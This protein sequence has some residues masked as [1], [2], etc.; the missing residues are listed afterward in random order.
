MRSSMPGPL[1]R[2]ATGIDRSLGLVLLASLAGLVAGLLL[3]A[4]TVRSMFIGRDF[5]LL[6]SVFSFLQSGD[7]FLFLVTFL[8]SV[9]FPVLKIVAGL[10]LWFVVDA[11][12]AYARP[13]LGWLATLSKWSMLDVFI[14]ALVV[15]VADGRLLSSADIQIG[16]IVFSVAVLVSTWATRRLSALAGN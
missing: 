4:I 13:V 12:D 9:V 7:W 10:V 16:A 15:L 5:S 3:P 11:T 2:R 1:S 14:I 8:F 6:E